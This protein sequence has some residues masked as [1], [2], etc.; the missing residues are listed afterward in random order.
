MDIE[1]LALV[2]RIEQFVEAVFG[3]VD[4]F[5]KKAQR[6]LAHDDDLFELFHGLFGDDQRRWGLRP[7]SLRQR[8]QQGSARENELEDSDGRLQGHVRL[9]LVNSAIP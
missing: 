6:R 1:L 2:Q 3:S 4:V 8:E 9:P 7:A 5:A